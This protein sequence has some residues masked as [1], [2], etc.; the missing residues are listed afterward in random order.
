VTAKGL[1]AALI[2]FACCQLAC[3]PL[4]LGLASGRIRGGDG[5]VGMRWAALVPVTGAAAG[6][7]AVVVSVASGDA[8]WLW[9]AIPACLASG[10]LV[11]L[12]ASMWPGKTAGRLSAGEPRAP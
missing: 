3:V 1:G 10:T 6:T 12:L 5:A 9:A 2:A 8:W 11:F 7:A 4:I